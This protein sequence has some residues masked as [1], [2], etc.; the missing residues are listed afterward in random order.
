M[1]VENYR[2]KLMKLPNLHCQKYDK[3]KRRIKKSKNPFQKLNIKPKGE[4]WIT[5]RK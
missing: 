1:C 2:P 4:R 5:L 3:L